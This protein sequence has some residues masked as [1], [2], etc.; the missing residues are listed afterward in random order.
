MSPARSYRLIHDDSKRVAEFVAAQM[1]GGAEFGPCT[2]LGFEDDGGLFFGVVYDLFTGTNVFMHC[3]ASRKRWMRREMLAD[4]FGYPFFQLGVD[5][6]TGPVDSRNEVALRFDKH[7]GFTEETRL[8]GAVPGGDMI[9]LVL[10]R[11]DC[12]WLTMKGVEKWHRR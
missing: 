7:I 10:W 6:I 12:K 3:G 9:M 1:P 5:R 11:N 8:R 2:A 4:V